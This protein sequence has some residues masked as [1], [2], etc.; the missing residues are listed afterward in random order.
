MQ[1]PSVFLRGL[2]CLLVL[3]AVG[4]QAQVSRDQP[5]PGSM[6]PYI[7]GFVVDEAGKPIRGARAELTPLTSQNYQ[8]AFAD[9]GGRF[10]FYELAEGRYRVTV[11]APGHASVTHTVELLAG[12]ET[13]R[14]MLPGGVAAV[15]PPPPA[16]QKSWEAGLKDLDRGRIEQAIQRFEQV[17]REAPD[18]APAYTNLGVA[19]LQLRSRDRARRAFDKALERD[20]ESAGAHLGLGLILNDE[21]RYSEAE[22]LLTKSRALNPE[23]WH[24][25]YELGRALYGLER[26]GEAETSLQQAAREKP[27]YGNLYLLLANVLVLQEKNAEGLQAMEQFLEVAPESP[28]V[29]Q[30]RE[31]AAL[32]RAELSRP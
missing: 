10:A 5:E 24:V 32:L 8:T 22:T 14:V 4:A 18:Y 7:D 15:A 30:V 3:H 6:A 9:A 2:A 28:L 16:G 13:L 1:G 11:T 23:D 31:K 19:Y 27:G 12:P 20:A 26:L 17:I 25:H 29:P 21:K